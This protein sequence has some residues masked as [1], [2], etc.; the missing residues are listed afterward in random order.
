MRDCL[1]SKEPWET[2]GLSLSLLRRQSPLSPLGSIFLFKK[3]VG[4]SNESPTMLDLPHWAL[5]SNESPTRAWAWAQARAN[6]QAKS[7]QAR[8]PVARA[9]LGSGIM[10]EPSLARL[11]LKLEPSSAQKYD[12]PWRLGCHPYLQPCHCQS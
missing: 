8:E 9:Q 1:S 6:T 11:K 10:F 5:L 4:L 7:S 3:N 2:M 12:E